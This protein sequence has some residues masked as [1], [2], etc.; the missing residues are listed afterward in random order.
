MAPLLAVAEKHEVV[1]IV[2]SASGSSGINF[3]QKSIEKAKII[4]T[5]GIASQLLRKYANKKGIP[6]F[7][8][9]KGVHRELVEFLRALKPDVTCVASM[10]QLLKRE[11]WEIP[12]LGTI[13]FHPSLL[14]KYRGP[15]PWFWQYYQMETEGGVTIFYVDDGEDTGDI[16]KQARYPIEPGIE[17]PAMQEKVISLGTTLLLETLDELSRGKVNPIPQRHLPCP[18]R[19]RNIRPDEAELIDWESWTIE[20]A[21]HFMRGTQLVYDAVPPPQGW[22]K[23]F[24]WKVEGFTL[25]P[26]EGV[27]GTV[28]GDNQGYFV[29][30]PQGKIRLSL[31][32]KWKDWARYW[33]S[34]IIK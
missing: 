12:K 30:H 17:L 28:Q 27:P 23:G 13:N 33:L 18:L 25:D 1:G 26:V 31:N 22:K 21:W 11:A 5:P 10:S 3:K 32:V 2:E 9:H 6:Y 15:S 16:L 8:L 29:T 19:A 4:F 14:P 7:L 34:K 24:R 20:R